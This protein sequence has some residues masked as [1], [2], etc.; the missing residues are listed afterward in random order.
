MTKPTEN[1]P[2]S[3]A[4]AASEAAIAAM[5]GIPPQ[6]QRSFFKAFGRV[7]TA[8]AEIPAQ[9]LED[10]A[11]IGHAR[12]R[13]EIVKCEA[14]AADIKSQQKAREIV[15]KESAK[16]AASQFKK[17][18]LAN[19]ALSFH[20]AHIIREQEIREDVIGI[21]ATCLADDCIKQDS[22][23]E[24]DDDWLS[25]FLKK[26]STRSQ[27]EFKQMFGRILAGEVKTPGTF[28][29]A[30]I[31]SLSRLTVDT[32]SLFQK[33]CNLTST[34]FFRPKIIS[35][36]FG[37]AGTNSLQKFGLSYFDLA[38][39]VEEGLIRSDFG[40]WQEMNSQLYEHKVPFEHAGITIF[41]VKDETLGAPAPPA[42]FRISG[43]TFTRAGEELRRIVTM[44]PAEEY[45]K[46]L[47]VWFK[48][49]GLI[50]H[51]VYKMEGERFYGQPL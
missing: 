42:T 13:I 16:A 7:F 8:S 31:Q 1:L 39:L 11:E 18:N 43:P 6:M 32:A 5:T 15:N 36:P 26:A 48:G 40:E 22:E 49:Q 30:T 29:I 2:I 21:A 14:E 46:A 34:G 37:N 35:D 19:R 3:V 45:L 23:N 50:L 38:R 51:I 41:L 9:W 20:A 33:A 24:I 25:V 10:R 47:A 28:S 12:R 17:E 44:A 4:D 27:D